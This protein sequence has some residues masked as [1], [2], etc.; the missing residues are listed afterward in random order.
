MTQA[1][2]RTVGVALVACLLA[3]LVACSSGQAGRGEPAPNASG[4]FVEAPSRP[5]QVCKVADPRLTEISG[6]AASTK[7]PGI[8]WTHNDSGDRAQVFALDAVTCEVRAV[9]HLAGVSARDTE[10]IAVGR[11]A[12]G[13]PTLWLADIGDNAANQPNVRLYRFREPS[14]IKDQT[15]N[16]AAVIKVKYIDEPYNAEALLVHP[17]PAGRMWIVT[18]RQAAQGAYYELPSSVWGASTT[19]TLKPVGSVP[20]MTTDATFAPDGRTYAIRT[21]FGGTQFAGLPP[22]SDAQPLDL[23][24]QGQSEALTYSYDSR[25]LYTISEGP[26]QPL[27]KV[28]LP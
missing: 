11:D 17:D 18:K 6:L 24:F 23:G 16:V 9:V 14:T 21:Y 27:T 12:A 2:A 13:N 22:G 26:N 1:L 3:V 25:L 8:L 10:A 28:P 15:V 7:H 5:E 19:V 4:P 20:A